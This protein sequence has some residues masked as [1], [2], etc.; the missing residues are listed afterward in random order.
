MQT[1]F[2]SADYNQEKLEQ[3]MEYYKSLMDKIKKADGSP[4]HQNM[5]IRKAEEVADKIRLLASEMK[6]L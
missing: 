1:V 3:M 5:L 2:T 6:K 4:A